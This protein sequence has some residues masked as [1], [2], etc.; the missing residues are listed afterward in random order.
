MHIIVFPLIFLFSTFAYTAEKSAITVAKIAIDIKWMTE[1]YPPYNYLDNGELSG[2]SVDLLKQIY[3]DLNVDFNQLHLSLYPWARAYK[4]LQDN[5][6]TCL[7]SMTHT[8]ER[9]EKF[10][11]VG[12]IIDTRISIIALSSRQFNA[13]PQSLEKLSIGV[14]KDDIGH[15][16][17]I[18][19]GIPKAQF[20]F[21]SSGYEM[22]K[23][24][25][26]GRVDL[27]AY[28][29]NIAKFQ[30]SKAGILPSQ[31]RVVSVLD[32][33]QLGF[34]CNK[35]VPKIFIEAMQ[36]SLIRIKIKDLQKFTWPKK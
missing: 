12:P 33:S 9:A 3:T 18:K 31:Y 11:F 19:K 8:K 22:V 20:V 1:D 35:K 7:F 2:L 14:V 30:F 36:K 24:L 26:L 25:A 23:M 15:Q 10:N 34:A 27:V 28:G 16:L 21:L 32:N 29:E 17:L 6:N 5:P 4:T 13:D